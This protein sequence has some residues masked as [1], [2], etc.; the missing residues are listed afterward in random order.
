[1]A[2][3]A[4]IRRTRCVAVVMG[5]AWL[6]AAASPSTAAETK[7]EPNYDESKIP[8][9]TLPDPLVMADGT[10]V[11]SVETWRTKRRPELIE[12]FE[13][14]VY[15]KAPGRPAGMT[16]E[17][18]DDDPNAL[19]GIATRKQITINFTGE[20][21]GLSADLL[22]YLPNRILEQ[23]KPAPTF[24][25]LNFFGNHTI[26]P[27]P[28]IRLS[29]RWMKNGYD[30]IQDH[31]AGEDCRG[32]RVSRFPVE[33]IIRRGFGLATIYY[34]D[35]DP[36]FDDGFKNGVHGVFDKA[37][38]DD[39]PKDAWGSIAAW[40]W[41]LRRA[42]DYFETDDDIDEKAVAVVGHS[43]L[44]KT[45][46]WAGA[47]DER[48]AVVISNN[49]GCGGAALSRRAFG[50]T[51]GRINELFPHWFC[52][53]NKAYAE[54]EN[55]LPVDQ[56]MLIALVA[57]RPVYVASAEKDRWAD[58]HG[59]FLSCLHAD[60]VYK[61]H[62]LEGLPVD[63]WPRLDHPVHGTIGYHYRRGGH[64]LTTY[65]WYRYLDFCDQHLRSNPKDR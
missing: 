41:G 17:V 21:D 50:E 16:F 13:T 11:E 27:D 37:K 26:H 57:P 64:D 15:G 4:T 46:L 8:A 23:G 34:G 6:V 56:H 49:S 22:V 65:D 28:A 1:M 48:F 36:D 60:P 9:Y 33:Q 32:L 24:V 7:W 30:C 59:E 55:E 10:R 63:E 29:T 62:G 31:R 12:L 51:V 25:I 61:L 39:R 44:G 52:T 35:I 14:Y 3:N 47:Q 53:N 18:F 42:M 19:G 43:R 40:A 5:M 54:R 20:K 45:S 2:M 58:P 38:G